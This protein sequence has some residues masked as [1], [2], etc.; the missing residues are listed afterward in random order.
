MTGAAAD[1]FQWIREIISEY[2]GDYIGLQEHFK[3][4][5]SSNQWFS[6]QFKDFSNF[7]RPAYRLPCVDYGRGRGG[8]V[9]LCNKSISVKKSRIIS[10]CP[11]IQTQI[12]NFVISKLYH[13]LGMFWEHQW[14][15]KKSWYH[16][17]YTLL[18]TSWVTVFMGYFWLVMCL[19]TPMM[20]L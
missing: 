16:F 7:I 19:M 14:Q 1:K 9:Q 17:L 3:T 2:E 12:L 5:K 10:N 20:S 18:A 13:K 8:L 11:R 15:K 4:V 6:N